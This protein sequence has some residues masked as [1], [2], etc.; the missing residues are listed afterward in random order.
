MSP[1]SD[2]QA[3]ADYAART[4]RLV[5]A[6]PE[7]HRMTQLLLAERV[8]AAGH[9]LV[10]GA[11]GGMELKVFAEA[12]PHW[13]LTGVDPAAEMLQ[14]ARATLGPLAERV[15]FCQGYIDDAPAGLFEG[16]TCLLTLHFL[17]AAERLRT[18]RQLYQRLRPGAPLV[19]AHH[20]FAQ[21]A[22][23]RAQWLDRYAAF[24]Q[25]SGVAPAQA[26]KGRTAIGTQLPLLTPAQDE[27][28]LYEAGFTQVQLF[29]T[30]FT[31]RGWVAYK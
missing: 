9:V 27:A 11:G 5:P 29:Y 21:Q 10:L 8:P 7:L 4:Q 19:V 25:A 1:F 16:A 13:H 12:H 30:A 14:L 23:E 24:A 18:L 17:P 2:P 26:D 20:S 22:P 31:F 3:V 28:L 15:H 6:L